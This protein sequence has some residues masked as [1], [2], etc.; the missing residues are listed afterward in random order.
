M[1]LRD[2]MRKGSTEML[3][4]LLLSAEP[5]YGYKIS[6]EL[7]K[8]S[9]G[10]FDIKEGLLYPTLHRLEKEGLVTSFWQK[11]GEKRRRKYYD[12]TAAGRDMLGEHTAEWARFMQQL[13]TLI[14]N[15]NQP[16]QTAEGDV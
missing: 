11:A 4:L 12:I 1:T 3:I 2:Q 9:D 10:Y 5:M 7:A 14:N 16:P 6:Q 8:Q 13:Q 15:Q